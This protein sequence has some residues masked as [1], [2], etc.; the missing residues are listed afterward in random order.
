MTALAI[1]AGLVS[2]AGSAAVVVIV[3]LGYRL[4]HDGDLRTPPAPRR[5]SN[6]QNGTPPQ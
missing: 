5:T 1:I 2:I 4:I 3:W 6:S